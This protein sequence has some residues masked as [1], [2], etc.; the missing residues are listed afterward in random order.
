MNKLYITTSG[1]VLIDENGTPHPF[2]YSREGISNIYF[3]KEDTTV[4]YERGEIKETIDA[5]AGDIIVSF[6][7]EDFPNKV[8]VVNNDKW[9]E[10]FIAYEEEQQKLKEK[11]AKEKA[12]KNCCDCGECCVKEG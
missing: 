1:R 9:K 7:E 11:W 12:E 6:Y 10:N 4:V 3:L 2:D 8:I 5:K